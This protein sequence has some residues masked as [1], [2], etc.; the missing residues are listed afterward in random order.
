MGIRR[1]PWRPTLLSLLGLEARCVENG[2]DVGEEGRKGSCDSEAGD[3]ITIIGVEPNPALKFALGHQPHRLDDIV[4]EVEPDDASI[5]EKRLA[6]KHQVIVEHDFIEEVE[7]ED[8]LKAE[9]EVVADVEPVIEHDFFN[10]IVPDDGLA[11]GHILM[12]GPDNKGHL[13]MEHGLVGK[14]DDLAMKDDVVSYNA[15]MRMSPDAASTRYMLST[16]TVT[17]MRGLAAAVS[18]EPPDDSAF[19]LAWYW[20]QGWRDRLSVAGDIIEECRWEWRMEDVTNWTYRSSLGMEAQL[21]DVRAGGLSS[22][23]TRE[24]K[25]RWA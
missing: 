8:I 6:A 7:S 25:V 2:G 17:C 10:D 4:E 22:K 5:T 16:D 13:D 9:E 12:N 20:A 18:K 23:G 24:K 14:E 3:V 19:R 11:T 21:K 15:M 1:Q